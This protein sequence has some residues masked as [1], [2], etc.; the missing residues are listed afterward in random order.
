LALKSS[1]GFISLKILDSCHAMTIAHV[2][3]RN[4][5]RNMQWGA[6]LQG[7][8]KKFA[9]YATTDTSEA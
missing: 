2:A 6:A 7:K 5:V 3:M 8:W 1:S 9:S 4:H